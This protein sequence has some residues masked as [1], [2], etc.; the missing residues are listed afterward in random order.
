MHT[1]NLNHYEDYRLI[2]NHEY[3]FLNDNERSR[4][5][6]LRAEIKSHEIYADLPPPPHPPTN[7]KNFNW[8]EIKNSIAKLRSLIKKTERAEAERAI[9]MKERAIVMADKAIFNSSIV[10][11]RVL[12]EITKKRL[13]IEKSKYPNC[14]YCNNSLGDNPHCDHIHPVSHGGL[15]TV[16]NMVYICSSCNLQKKDYTLREFISMCNLNRDEVEDKLLR[17]GKRI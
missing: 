5:T 16:V 11:T 2:G 3:S 13:E 10:K 17:M 8:P 9:V 15:S 6:Q 4:L 1:I 7:F 12:A 14:P